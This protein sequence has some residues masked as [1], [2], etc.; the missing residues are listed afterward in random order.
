MAILMDLSPL[1]FDGVE[2]E[3]KAGFIRSIGNSALFLTLIPRVYPQLS[4]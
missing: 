3:N 2:R 1:E 4:H